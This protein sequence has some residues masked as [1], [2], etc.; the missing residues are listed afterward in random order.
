[1]NRNGSAAPPLKKTPHFRNRS[2]SPSCKRRSFRGPELSRK[3]S[4][5]REF[6]DSRAP[7][8][9]GG[10]IQVVGSAGE[11]LAGVLHGPSGYP[12]EHAAPSAWLVKP[13]IRLS[14]PGAGDTPLERGLVSTASCPDDPDAGLVGLTAPVSTIGFSSTRAGE[15]PL[16]RGLTSGVAAAPNSISR[17]A[18]RCEMCFGSPGW[19]ANCANLLRNSSTEPSGSCP[20]SLRIDCSSFLRLYEI[21]CTPMMR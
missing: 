12:E 19:F 9:W 4:R 15:T 3:W 11:S 1:M 7:G 6:L 13:G 20:N 5:S 2:A 14:P 17:S 21:H 8:I 16:E 18:N 10:T